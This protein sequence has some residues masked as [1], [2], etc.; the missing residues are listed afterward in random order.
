VVSGLATLYES[1]S[2]SGAP[3]ENGSPPLGLTQT[4][5][6][7][8]YPPP[9]STNN[10]LQPKHLPHDM[11]LMFSTHPMQTLPHPHDLPSQRP[12]TSL[13]IPQVLPQQHQPTC[14][15]SSKPAGRP[16]LSLNVNT[17]TQKRTFG[18]GS[19]LR[20]E[21]LSAVSP[22]V[23]NTFANAYEPQKNQTSALTEAP[24]SQHTPATAL[25]PR[26]SRPKL[27][28]DSSVYVPEKPSTP[29]TQEPRTPSSSSI[30]SASTSN[31]ATI[32][33][34]VSHSLHSILANSPIL[35]TDARKMS[36]RPRFPAEKKVSFRTP[37]VEEIHTTRFTLAHSDILSESSSTLSISTDSVSSE[38]SESMS[39]P[40]TSTPSDSSS[41]SSSDS[42]EPSIALSSSQSQSTDSSSNFV[43]T[44]SETFSTQSTSG[45]RL[46]HRLN[47]SKVKGRSPRAGDKRDSSSESD[48]DAVPETP[49]AGRRKRRREWVW[50]LGPLPLASSEETY[51]TSADE[52]SP[53]TSTTFS[54]TLSSTTRS[55][56]SS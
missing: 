27:S 56:E 1:A 47:R 51:T 37:L 31:S 19:S 10:L 55:D 9:S 49:V 15:S 40:S 28:I 38:A 39:E 41:S 3:A 22:T 5:I 33:Y 45:L 24:E 53:S 42:S 36:G 4:V 18:K 11:M 8:R 12:M 29:D 48:S 7:I 30:S 26:L 20:L 46:P 44:S 50:T 21:T 23:V 16:K 17:T 14:S 54:S 25:G 34:S 52:T 2:V 43:S 13:V 6:W 35:R 32:P